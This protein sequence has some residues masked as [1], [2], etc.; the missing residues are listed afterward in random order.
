MSA[1]TLPQAPGAST[2]KT[3]GILSIVLG[4]L[5]L[6]VGLV[7]AII[8][9]VQ[10]HKAKRAYATNP[11]S[12]QPVGSVGL[13]TAILGL[14]VPPVLAMIGILAAIAIPSF[15]KYQGQAR[16]KVAL[17]TMT[18]T[19][20]DLVV[21]YDRLAAGQTATER[22]PPALEAK[23]RSIGAGSKNPWNPATPAFTY[24]IEV[25]KAAD[26]GSL[27]Q[28]AETRATEKGVSVFVMALPDPSSGYPG[29]LAGAV[30]VLVPRNEKSV[31][32][33]VQALD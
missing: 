33:K 32:T 18:E 1:A 7:L 17:S 26:Q 20:R 3:T 30:R 31:I 15:L 24:T 28:A 14:V 8:A 23:L 10:H 16:D 25:I 11:E 22:I 5:C 29:H 13:V 12:F 21:E 6:P 4:I 9:L 19:L 27:A 2:A